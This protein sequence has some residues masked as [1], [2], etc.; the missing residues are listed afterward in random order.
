M[1][2][3]LK[4]QTH[5]QQRFRLLSIK[6]LHIALFRNETASLKGSLCAARNL[7]AAWEM[8]NDMSKKMLRQADIYKGQVA[9]LQLQL[10]VSSGLHNRS[11]DANASLSRSMLNEARDE[12][13]QSPVS[14]NMYSHA[15][16]RLKILTEQLVVQTKQLRAMMA[17][18]QVGGRYPGTRLTEIPARRT[19]LGSEIHPNLR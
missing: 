4:R 15:A 16:H 18:G 5:L 8:K 1:D 3:L 13:A 14:L 6:I 9:A 2:W 7:L 11:T 12:F 17:F 19:S 10:D